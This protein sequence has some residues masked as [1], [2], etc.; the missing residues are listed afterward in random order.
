[1]VGELVLTGRVRDLADA[2]ACQATRHRPAKPRFCC[3]PSKA[4]PVKRRPLKYRR[5]PAK[6]RELI[7]RQGEIAPR[8]TRRVV[9]IEIAADRQDLPAASALP[10]ASGRG[11]GADA[12]GPCEAKAL[13]VVPRF[14]TPSLEPGE[15]GLFPHRPSRTKPLG[16]AFP[17]PKPCSPDTVGDRPSALQLR[18]LRPPGS[19]LS[20]SQT[21]KIY[22]GTLA[23]TPVFPEW[24]GRGAQR[25]QGYCDAEA[26][27][28][29]NLLRRSRDV[30]K[31]GGRQATTPDGPALTLQVR[32]DGEAPSRIKINM[33]MNGRQHVTL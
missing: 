17:S 16:A 31:S 3:P 24:D 1:V 8:T 14:S 32:L 22:A 10:P 12:S 33:T 28:R 30:G 27:P 7:V 26:N 29:L 15:S 9:I 4:S 5:G 18:A 23:S 6:N 25:D 19:V 20:A 13:I 21:W 2:L 11:S